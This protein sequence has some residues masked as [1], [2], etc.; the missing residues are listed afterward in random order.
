M[1]AVSTTLC[2]ACA[3][4][5]AVGVPW[6]GGREAGKPHDMY[7]V[8]LHV[9]VVVVVVGELLSCL[10]NEE[11]MAVQYSNQSTVLRTYSEYS[12]SNAL[13]RPRLSPRVCFALV[14]SDTAIA[15]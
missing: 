11:C 2:H 6:S 10:A 5:H 15:S 7:V 3:M 9:V 13:R 12:Y 8:A 1:H 14:S 4:L